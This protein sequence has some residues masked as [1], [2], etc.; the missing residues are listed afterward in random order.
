MDR[1]FYLQQRIFSLIE[2]AAKPFLPHQG[3][4]KN[5]EIRGPGKI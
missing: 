5:V 1:R 2:L 3:A 4:S